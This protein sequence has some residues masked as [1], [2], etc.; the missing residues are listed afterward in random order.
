M[1]KK[2]TRASVVPEPQQRE[3]LLVV[4]EL[5]GDWPML[6]ELDSS[7]RRVM[8]QT[9][10][11]APGAFAERVVSSLD[12]LF[13]P[14]VRL[15]TVAIACNERVDDAA[16]GAR[17]KVAGLSLGS[18]AKNKAGRVYLTTSERSNGRLRHALTALSRGLHE[19]WRTA[20]LDV[21][22]DLGQALCSTP[23]ATA[24]VAPTFTARV[25]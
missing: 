21:S 23:T 7:V 9:E 25:A 15:A 10:G 17:R 18:M 19:E 1:R 13:G 5:G 2:T 16:D 4:V 8:A 20:G 14:G 6:R 22:V 12:D 3:G 24:V 11:E